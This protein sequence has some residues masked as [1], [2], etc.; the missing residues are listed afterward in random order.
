MCG[1]VELGIGAEK[2]GRKVWMHTVF[3]ESAHLGL[4]RG[5]IPRGEEQKKGFGGVADRLCWPSV[6]VFVAG[7]RSLG[8][9]RRGR[10]R[11]P[12]CSV[13]TREKQGRIFILGTYKM[14]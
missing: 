9:S 12:P 4:G 5:A 13:Y 1:V 6:A 8:V 7:G 3:N 10:R 2:S 11:S 14:S